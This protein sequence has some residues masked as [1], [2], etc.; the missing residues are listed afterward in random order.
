MSLS[1]GRAASVFPFSQ[2]RKLVGEIGRIGIGRTKTA[3]PGETRL[4]AP[5]NVETGFLDFLSGIRLGGASAMLFHHLILALF[6]K[7]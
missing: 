7:G 3:I 1:E 5:T 2:Q 4:A 6:D